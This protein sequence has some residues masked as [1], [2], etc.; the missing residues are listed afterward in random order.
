M[1][2]HRIVQLTKGCDRGRRLLNTKL[3]YKRLLAI[4]TE[5]VAIER[6]FVTEALP[7]D[8]IGMNSGL[9]GEYIEFVA[10]RLLVALGG[11]K[12]FAAKNPFDWMEMLSLQCAPSTADV[13]LPDLPPVSLPVSPFQLV[14]MK[15]GLYCAASVPVLPHV[16]AR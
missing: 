2:P 16:F 9:M 12:H 3:E 5:A 7:V 8:L 13:A 14:R 11:D 4:V 1:H 6:E 15:E 10:D